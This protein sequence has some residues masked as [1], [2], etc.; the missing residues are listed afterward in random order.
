MD[1]V[2]EEF[3]AHLSNTPTLDPIAENLETKC[4]PVASRESI[5]FS[6]KHPLPVR[7]RFFP[8]VLVLI[9]IH[10][11]VLKHQ[12]T[13]FIPIDQTFESR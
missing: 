2:P 7:L 12:Q 1:N 8:A 6:K 5:S 13:N 4:F 3:P 10:R 9:R 11:S